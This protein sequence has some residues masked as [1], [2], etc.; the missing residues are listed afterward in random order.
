MYRN[1]EH[2][3]S[4]K[5][6]HSVH[7]HA[8]IIT[9]YNSIPTYNVVCILVNNN[10]ITTAVQKNGHTKVWYIKQLYIDAMYLCMYV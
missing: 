3:R 10:Y 6:R 7:V 9:S 2:I 5:N 8:V 4:I 1:L